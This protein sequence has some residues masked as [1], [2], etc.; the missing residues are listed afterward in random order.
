MVVG[1]IPSASG[2]MTSGHLTLRG[3]TLYIVGYRDRIEHRHFV[4][5]RYKIEYIE[6][7]Q[8]VYW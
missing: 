8:L 4:R 5:D 6:H 7:F 3:P 2:Q 1:A